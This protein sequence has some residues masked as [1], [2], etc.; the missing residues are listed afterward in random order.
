MSQTKLG[1][2]ILCDGPSAHRFRTQG[3]FQACPA[4]LY[5]VE[6]PFLDEGPGDGPRDIDVLF[7]GN[8]HP[9]A[10]GER[11]PWLAR[12]ARLAPRWKVQVVTDA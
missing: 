10:Q 5:G 7:A 4:L 2:L 8:L 9:A 11:L 12:L 3:L 1:Y 6:R